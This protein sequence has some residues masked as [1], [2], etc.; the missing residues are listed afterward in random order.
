MAYQVSDLPQVMLYRVSD[1]Q[2]RQQPGDAQ[3]EGKR[4]DFPWE[5][6]HQVKAS[7]WTAYS[8]LPTE[9]LQRCRSGT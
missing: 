6:V 9:K 2:A 7:T 3:T 1:L 5:D 4:L 8:G